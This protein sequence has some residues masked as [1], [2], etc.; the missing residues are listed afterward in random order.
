VAER[1]ERDRRTMEA[2]PMLGWRDHDWL[3]ALNP[4]L[5]IALAGP[6]KNQPPDFAPSI[7]V[8]RAVT[9]W[10]A[11]GLE[12]YTDLG[13]VTDIKP[14]AQ[15]MR[16]LYVATDIDRPPWV[17]NFGVGRGFGEASDAWTVKMIFEIPI[18]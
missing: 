12:Y 11:L 4:T 10:A 2:R 17:F 5:D 9:E 15:Q 1:F 7:K 14:Y 3:V 18:D 16:S 13:P 8:S 6:D